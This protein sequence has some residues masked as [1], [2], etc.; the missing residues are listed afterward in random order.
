MPRIYLPLL[1]IPVL[2]VIVAVAACT[3]P[4]SGEPVSHVIPS[5]SPYVA[6]MGAGP[7]TPATP[8]PAH[9]LAAASGG[10]ETPSADEVKAFERTVPK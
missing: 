9:A 6:A 10:D 4:R 7:A 2:A 5:P 3:R 1:P 8:A